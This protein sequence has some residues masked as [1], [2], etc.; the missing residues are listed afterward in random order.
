[1]AEAGA[2]PKSARPAVYSVPPHRPFAD[3]LVSGLL[4]R[5]KGDRL[6]L[7]RGTILV[8]N[9]RAKRAITD[10]FVR[11]AEGGLLLPR[12]VAGQG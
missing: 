4:V 12:I 5:T 3:A 11:R 1:M 10:A 2:D 8:P 7:A 6:S 9:N